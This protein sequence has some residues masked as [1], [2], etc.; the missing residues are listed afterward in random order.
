MPLV[1]LI[2]ERIAIEGMEFV[3]LGPNSD[4]RNCKLKTVCFNLKANR[5]YK[6]TKIREKKHSCKIH[7]GAAAVVEVEEI[8]IITSVNKKYSEGEKTKIK[9]EECNSIGCEYYYL[10]NH[11]LIPA[12]RFH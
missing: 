2:G 5:H 1:T 7:E 4:C 9:K 8:P 6:I 3:Y 12:R 11:L 10:C